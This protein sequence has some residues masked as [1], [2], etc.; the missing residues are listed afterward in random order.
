M[1]WPSPRSLVGPFVVDFTTPNYNHIHIDYA[2]FA[3]PNFDANEY[4]NAILGAQPYRLPPFQPPSQTQT[5]PPQHVRSSSVATIVPT[6]T[7]KQGTNA[8]IAGSSTLTASGPSLASVIL[9]ASGTNK[10]EISVAL[11]KLSFGVDDVNRQLK[12]VINVHHEAL[13]SRAASVNQ[14]EGS[15]N[16]VNAGLKDISGSVSRLRTKLS[17]PY[18]ALRTHATRLQKLQV[19]SD[20][21]RRVARFFMLSRRL[22]VQMALIKQGPT[23]TESIVKSPTNTKADLIK[24]PTSPDT[25]R[26][27]K[28][29][30]LEKERERTIIKAALSVAEI[31]DSDLK[32]DEDG[33]LQNQSDVHLDKDVEESV[34][35]EDD[36]PT[37]L[38][39]ISL[40][41]LHVI[42]S[43][44][45]NVETAREQIMSEMEA[46]LVTGV[47]ELN[48]PLLSSALLTAHNLRILPETVQNLLGDL[49]EVVEARVKGAF[50]MAALSKEKGVKDVSAAVSAASTLL[51]KSRV[52]TEPTNLTAPQWT[53]AFWVYT[54]EKVLVAQKDASTGRPFLDEVMQVLEN[55]PS[56]S[57]WS[58]LARTLEKSCREGAKSQYPRLLRLFQDFFSRISVHTETVYTQAHQSPETVITLRAVSTFESLYLQ[59]STTRLNE[60][61]SSAFA[62]SPAAYFGGSNFVTSGGYMSTSIASTKSLPGEKDGLAIARVV[63]NELDASRFDPLL[64]MSTARGIA[65]CL[66]T[67]GSRVDNLVVKDRS[68]TTLIGPT[69][70]VQQ[71]LNASIVNALYHCWLQLSKLPEGYSDG[72]AKILEPAV[73]ALRATFSRITDPLLS[74][75]RLDISSIIS[76]VHR[77]DFAEEVDPMAE[78]GGTSGYLKELADKLAYVRT[79]VLSKYNLGELGQ[80]CESGKLQL[81]ADMTQLEFALDSLMKAG[82]AQGSTPQNWSIDVLGADYRAIRGMRYNAIL[83]LLNTRSHLQTS[84]LPPL[85]VL[86]HILVRSPLPLP[87]RLHGWQEPQYVRFVEEHTDEDNERRQSR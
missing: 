82:V 68:A 69:V 32:Q 1:T 47:Q 40:R 66:E 14:L 65:K 86:H 13:L 6:D 72:V 75:I 38:P 55:K 27:E 41:A 8:S 24:S 18:A 15:L 80:D 52:R 81:T 28:E 67:M 54:L 23:Y 3:H 51:Y 4:A 9:D 63:A 61:I 11:A 43:H 71:I 34:D 36:L 22:E 2:I 48:R 70:T 60:L 84:G 79:E 44:L 31:F 17:N 46:M 42:S 35:H 87:H 58:I 85:V 20:V 10:E 30:D 56:S 74:S 57:F 37:E 26:L 29:D 83:L 73:Q 62:T 64:V 76:R 59:R 5:Q 16:N 12:N 33:N 21:L 50:D 45:P 39:P 25:P 53:N 7:T 49:I 77:I 78:M 19:A